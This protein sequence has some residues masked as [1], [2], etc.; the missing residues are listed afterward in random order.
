MYTK[1]DAWSPVPGLRDSHHIST[2]APIDRRFPDGELNTACNAL[3]HLPAVQEALAKAA[4]PGLPVTVKSTC[5][6][7]QEPPTPAPAKRCSPP[8]GAWTPMPINAGSPTVPV[9]GFKLRIV[10]GLG[11][12]LAVIGAGRLEKEL[13]ALVRQEIGPVAAFKNAMIVD[14]LPQTRSGRILR[15]TMRQIADGGDYAVPSTIEDSSVIDAPF[16]VLR[17]Q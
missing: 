12:H 5:S 16:P 13:I 14:A 17:R 9:P 15:K 4:L 10:D 8:V 2:E 6:S 1:T 7:L 3:I 11:Q